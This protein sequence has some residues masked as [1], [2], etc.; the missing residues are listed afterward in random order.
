MG[1]V[2]YCE[3]R[4]RVEAERYGAFLYAPDRSGWIFVDDKLRRASSAGAARGVEN[5]DGE[6]YVWECCPWCGHDLR[7]PR[8]DIVWI[9]DDQ[10]DG[11]G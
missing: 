8:F 5:H 7:P 10:G 9:P 11:G 3:C 1:N 2:E 4:T 6:P